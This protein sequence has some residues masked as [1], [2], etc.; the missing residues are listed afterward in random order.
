MLDA[1]RVECRELRG[2][3][4]E[5][6]RREAQQAVAEARH[7][8][9]LVNAREPILQIRPPALRA[10]GKLQALLPTDGAEVLGRGHGELDAHPALPSAPS[11]TAPRSVSAAAP[12]SVPATS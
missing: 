2:P 3:L 8:L 1:P 6:A 7:D 5:R 4:R 10:R 11:R 9:R 12:G